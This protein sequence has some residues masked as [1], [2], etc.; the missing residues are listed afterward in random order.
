MCN[1]FSY[2]NF[3]CLA[4]VCNSLPHE[5]VLFVSMILSLILSVPCSFQTYFCIHFKVGSW[6]FSCLLNMLLSRISFSTCSVLDYASFSLEPVSYLSD[7]K[8]VILR[9]RC[10]AAEGQDLSKTLVQVSEVFEKGKY[11]HYPAPSGLILKNG[12]EVQFTYYLRHNIK[13]ALRFYVPEE[14]EAVLRVPIR[15]GDLL[16]PEIISTHKER[17]RTTEKEKRKMG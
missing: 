11:I 6:L 7:K 1:S 17:K 10:Y 9:I 5:Y 3:H 8:Q 13:Y 4:G 12:K 14:T 2:F 15:Y 16:G